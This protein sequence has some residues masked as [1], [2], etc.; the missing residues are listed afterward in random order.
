MSAAPSNQ[1]APAGREVR[2]F[3]FGTFEVDVEQRELR[4]RGVRVPL[5]QKPFC[6][7]ELLLRKS[8]TLVTRQE[9][10]QYLWPNLH[11]SFDRGLNTAINVLRR[12]LGESHKDSAYIETRAGLGYRFIAPVQAIYASATSS[13]THQAIESVAVLPF[14]SE[15]GNP[16]LALL[17]GEITDSVTAQLSKIRELRVI[18]QTSKF[19]FSGNFQESDSAATKLN[20]QAVL[21]GRVSQ[22]GNSLLISAALVET[23]SDRRLWGADYETGRPGIL[24]VGRNICLGVADALGVRA[25]VLEIFQNDQDSFEA[26]EHYAKGRYFYKRMAEEDL[27]KSI[28]FFEAALA[29]D[30]QYAPAFTG[31]ADT[32]TLLALLGVLKPATARARAMDL[33]MTAIDIQPDLAE[34]HAS[35]AGIKKLFDW[36]WSG[37]E[38]GYLRA[39]ELN[40]NYADAHRWYS[41][42]LC[43]LGRI[44]EAKKEMRAAQRLDPVSLAISSDCAWNH[45]MARDFQGAVEQAWKTLVMD[46]KYAPAQHTL[47]MA[48]EH[49]GMDQ[50][51]ITELQNARICSGEHPVTIA[52]LAHA[53]GALGMRD[54]A[55]RTI[56]ELDEILQRRYVPPYCMSIA[57]AGLEDHDTAL[58]WLD[59]AVE[60][61]DVWLLWLRQ[62][63][64]FDPLRATNRFGR[65]IRNLQLSG[66]AASHQAG[67]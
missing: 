20:A 57:Y 22:R 7:L 10:A 14:E 51:A 11:V 38:A 40:P 35:L 43:S 39:I 15:Q 63:P 5:Q 59:K 55:L 27:R 54:M 34:A 49:L 23:R 24:A 1:P 52:S 16:E 30:P 47:G 56:K 21:T 13:H 61:R 64:R 45:F 17:A 29:H 3:L 66:D 42:L 25:E 2:L 67:G 48:Y 41:A 50:E 33:V 46:A 9:L 19:H 37:A 60:E 44:E 53:Y 62:D 58:A 31:L 12:A 8:G 6:V 32:Y 28:A 36:D 65:L 4:N 18:S 26:H